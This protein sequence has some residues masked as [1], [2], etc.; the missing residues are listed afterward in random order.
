VI[1]SRP[2]ASQSGRLGRDL[3]TTFGRARMEG[4]SVC[5]LPQHDSAHAAIL[6]L[7]P[8]DVPLVRAEGVAGAWFRAWWWSAAV[9]RR[10][11]SRC[12]TASAA[13]WLEWHR[14]LKR[15]AGDE[16]LPSTVRTALRGRAHRALVRSTDRSASTTSRVTPLARRLL[17]AH[18][19]MSLPPALLAE[20]SAAAAEVG[21][22]DDRPLVG[23]DVRRKRDACTE[24]LTWLI[25]QGYTVVRIVDE[26]DGL[27][28]PGVIDLSARSRQTP[29]LAL[30]VWLRARFVVCDSPERQHVAY[31]TGTPSLLLNAPDPFRGY[32]VRGDGLF[33]LS[34][35]I[36]LDTGRT[37]TARERLDERFFRNLRN[38]GFRDNGAAEVLAAV[39]E[40]HDGV[41]NGWR[42]TASQTRFRALVEE[43][44]T[45]LA[46]R[47]P[48]VA[49]WGPDHGFMGDGRLVRWQAD[50]VE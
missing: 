22:T 18:V 49:E 24:A 42:D 39:R 17:R 31:L 9:A 26:P 29:L 16:G 20:A 30:H 46:P 34:T 13:F 38:C 14:E 37:L 4:A 8:D 44:G 40:M 45:D 7:V 27:G 32:P 6:A 25:E 23:F 15:R 10:T 47:V 11:T 50:Q 48:V 21:I 43:A 36:D 3:L 41:R 33:T 19:R 28:R 5:V 12:A 2:D 1:V 35:A